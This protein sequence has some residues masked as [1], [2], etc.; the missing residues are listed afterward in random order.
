MY[1]DDL[2]GTVREPMGRVFSVI[3]THRNYNSASLAASEAGG[4]DCLHSLGLPTTPTC[5]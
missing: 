4:F 1:L 5:R 3:L 2:I